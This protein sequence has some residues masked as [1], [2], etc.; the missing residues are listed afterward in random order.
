MRSRSSFVRACCQ[1]F[2]EKEP[3]ITGDIDR[4]IELA[5]GWKGEDKEEPPIQKMTRTEEDE[6]IRFLKAPDLFKVILEDFE[7]IG[8]TG[9][10]ANKLIGYLAAISRKLEE[11]LS[12]LIQSRSAAGKSTLQDA[13]LSLIPEE[14]YVK[15]TRLTNQALFYKEEDSLVHKVLAIEEEHGARDASYSIRNIQSSKYLSIAATGKDPVTGKLKTEEY[16]V[17]GPVAL[18]ITTTEAELDYETQNRFITLSIDESKEMTERILFKQR[19]GETLEGL[20]KKVGVEKVKEKHQNI[21]RLLRPLHIINPYASF[22][23]FPSESLRSR[24]D[25][26]KYLGLIKAIAFLHQYQREIKDFT[27]PSGN[28]TGANEFMQYI[29]VQIED[30]EKANR[31]AGEVLGRTLDELSPPSRNLLKMIREMVEAR[32][33]EQDIEPKEYHFTRKDVRDYTRWSDFQVKCHIK[34]LEYMEY[35]Y[36]VTGKK[37]KEY[38]Y[39]LLYAGEGEDGS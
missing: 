23:T 1:L 25:H 32:C 14:D 35:L 24:R 15:Y 13:I 5:D 3:L 2:S 9:E 36:S 10:E 20:I 31:L 11:P 33:R 7:T 37:G 38:V 4:I 28:G 27:L 12:I 17:K 21:Q 6:A 34:Q 26:K 18:M 22:L 29:E 19:E 30:I 8:C 39:E 16:R